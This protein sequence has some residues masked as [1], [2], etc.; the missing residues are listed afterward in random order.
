LFDAGYGSAAVIDPKIDPVSLIDPR[1][2]PVAIDGS[3]F[4]TRSF[5]SAIDPR[6]D[7]SALPETVTLLCSDFVVDRVVAS[8]RVTLP[9]GFI[10]V[11]GGCAMESGKLYDA[12]FGSAASIDPK[13]DPVSSIDPRVDPVA[14]SGEL[15]FT[16][17]FVSAVDPKTDP[18]SRGVVTLV[19]SVG[20]SDLEVAT[21]DSSV[22]LPAGVGDPSNNCNEQTTLLF[23]AGFLSAASIDPKGDPV[24]RVG[25][26]GSG[27]SSVDPKV[28][29]VAIDGELKI[30]RTLVRISKSTGK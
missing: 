3:L 8:K 7:P 9:A 24:S 2:D 29:P 21:I 14:V 11:G 12:G 1:G 10:G 28:D 19:C 30:V 17:S 15:L 13:T 27:V 6:T 25:P 22:A 5:V 18:V 20:I 16:R 23:G 4:L 26:K